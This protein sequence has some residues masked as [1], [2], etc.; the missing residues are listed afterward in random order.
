MTCLPRCTSHWL[1]VNFHYELNWLSAEREFK[2]AIE[3]NPNLARA[4]GEY[5]FHLIAIGRSD[6][7][8]REAQRAQDLDPLSGVTYST[9]QSIYMF[10]RQYDRAIENS[11][12]ELEVHP[13]SANANRSLAWAYEAKGICDE[14]V[15]ARQKSMTLSGESAED[16]AALRNAYEQRAWGMWV[17]KADPWFD[18]LRCDPR[19]QDLLRRMNF[20]E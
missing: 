5:A 15:A 17:L 19:F 10:A 18:P 16:V 11:R 4:H 14:S 20:P 8:L 2:R 1:Y 7:A 3:L 6:E 9:V 12:K 13:D